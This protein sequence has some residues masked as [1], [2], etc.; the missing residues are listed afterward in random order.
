MA[1]K[2]FC[3]IALEFCRSVCPK[4]KCSK[5]PPPSNSK[6]RHA[7]RDIQEIQPQFPLLCRRI[8]SV[9]TVSRVSRWSAPD[10]L[11]PGCPSPPLLPV[12]VNVSSLT[13]WL[14]DFQR[15]QF[16]GSSG[17]FSFLNLLLSFFWLCEEAKCIY[18]SLHLG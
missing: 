10:T 5:I 7:R 3:T 12:W 18:L 13:P 17:Y 11:L 14:L 2:A 16:P 1:K 4:Y 15:V 6:D 9:L 8:S